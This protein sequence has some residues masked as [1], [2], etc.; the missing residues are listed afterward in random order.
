MAFT[1]NDCGVDHVSDCTVDKIC[2]GDK[3]LNDNSWFEH[4]AKFSQDY[5]RSLFVLI[6]VNLFHPCFVFCH[7]I[8]LLFSRYVQ[9]KGNFVLENIVTELLLLQRTL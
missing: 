2:V 1:N 7:L 9:F 5:S 6:R 3:D 8:K 4:L